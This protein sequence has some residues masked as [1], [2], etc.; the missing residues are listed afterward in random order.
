M[1]RLTVFFNREKQ[2]EHAFDLETVVI[3]RSSECELTIDNAG[4]SRQ[5]CKIIKQGKFHILQD[6]NSNNGTFVAGQMITG[7]RVL[8]PGEEIGVGKHLIQFDADEG[9]E[10]AEG[11]VAEPAVDLE[12]G[13]GAMTMQVDAADMIRMQI[14]RAAKVKG[15]LTFQ[16]GGEGRRPVKLE[17]AY[18]V[19]GSWDRADIPTSGFGVARKAAIIIREEVNYRVIGFGRFART[20]VNGKPVE[21][22]VLNNGDEIQVGKL[23]MRFAAG[24]PPS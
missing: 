4:V 3:G 21:D 23:V 20:R 2:S 5:H 9:G 24:E 7:P 11:F 19:I 8:N 17:K 12:G 13:G 6:L 1:I 22:Q 15:Y 16:K 18:Y 10:G 14:Q